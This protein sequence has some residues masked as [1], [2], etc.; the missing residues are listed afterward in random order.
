[1]PTRSFSTHSPTRATN[2]PAEPQ[3]RRMDN[4]TQASAD[5]CVGVDHAWRATVTKLL[6]ETQLADSLEDAL[7]PLFCLLDED[8]DDSEVLLAVID[9]KREEWRAEL[10]DPQ[11]F[12]LP[13]SYRLDFAVAIHVYTLGKYAVKTFCARSQGHWAG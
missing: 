12:A 5:G 2:A 9:G 4:E 7:R 3:L 11:G 10:Y 8:A 1:M 13:P 6:R